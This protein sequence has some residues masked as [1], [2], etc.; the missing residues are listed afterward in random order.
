MAIDLRARLSRLVSRLPDEDVRATLA[1]AEERAA[2]RDPLEEK[3][4]AAPEENEEL[5]D[6]E[7]AAIRDGLADREA[8]RV[9]SAESVKRELGI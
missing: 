2:Q 1:F 4:L 5:G 9:Y 7:V 3:L 8:G 6:D